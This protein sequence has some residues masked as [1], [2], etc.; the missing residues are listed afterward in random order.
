MK[1]GQLIDIV[2]GNMFGKYTVLNDFEEWDLNP[3]SF[4]F[5]NVPQLIKNQI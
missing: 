4:Q 2:M 1:L 5:K 3:G